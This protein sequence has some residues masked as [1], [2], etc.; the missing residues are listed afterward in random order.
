MSNKL[1]ERLHAVDLY[2]AH[3]RGFELILGRDVYLLHTFLS[4]YGHRQNAVY[5]AYLAAQRKLA[6]KGGFF[7]A[8]GIY[9]P[10]YAKQGDGY[11]KVVHRA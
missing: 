6:D 4:K 5:P 2:A 3:R 11:R 9:L 10:R 8:R 7:D 1:A